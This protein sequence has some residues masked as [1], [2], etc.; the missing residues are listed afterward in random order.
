MIRDEWCRMAIAVS[1]SH[2]ADCDCAIDSGY[3]WKYHSKWEGRRRSNDKQV[4]EPIRLSQEPVGSACRSIRTPNTPHVAA[5][6]SRQ[7][8]SR[9]ATR[10]CRLAQRAA[11]LP[12]DPEAPQVW[13][14]LGQ[15]H[16]AGNDKCVVQAH[17]VGYTHV[18][19][20]VHACGRM[21]VCVRARVSDFGL[22]WQSRAEAE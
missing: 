19:V 7:F 21:Y 17:V 22:P 13:D 11:A 3:T 5:T 20:W 2:N 16:V 18:F 6:C 15:R 1:A 9:A 12:N 8:C 14:V 4:A 10:C